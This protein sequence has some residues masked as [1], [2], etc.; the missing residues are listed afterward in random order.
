MKNQTAPDFYLGGLGGGGGEGNWILIDGGLRG[1]GNPLSTD[2]G[3]GAVGWITG[4]A[5]EIDHP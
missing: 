2:G 3:F 1:D 4:Q 5:N